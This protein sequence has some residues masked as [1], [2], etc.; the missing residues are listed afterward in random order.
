MMDSDEG[1]ILGGQSAKRKF[2]GPEMYNVARRALTAGLP[3]KRMVKRREA[4]E[5][6]ASSLDRL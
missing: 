6:V 2:G 3:G 1:S 4:N 5:D